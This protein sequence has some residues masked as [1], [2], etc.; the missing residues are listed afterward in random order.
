M[1]YLIKKICLLLIVFAVSSNAQESN[2]KDYYFPIQDFIEPKIYK[3]EDYFDSNNIVYWMLSTETRNSETYLI[4]RAFDKNH[5]QF[6][7]F[8]EQITTNGTVVTSFTDIYD[9][10]SETIG[11]VES[12]NVFYWDNNSLCF[13]RI[14]VSDENYIF[15]KKRISADYKLNKSFKNQDYKCLVMNDTYIIR[16]LKTEEETYKYDQKTYYAKDIGVIG[17][18]RFFLDGT[19]QDFRLTQIIDNINDFEIIR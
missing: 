5:K 17:Y 10:D 14:R 18:K 16:D 15:E 19:M 13:F 8:K 12:N 7:F 1:R 9:T 3:Y 4:T 2:Y 6:E 11:V